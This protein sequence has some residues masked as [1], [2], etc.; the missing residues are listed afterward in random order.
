MAC[1]PQS[2]LYPSI[3]L[4]PK[5]HLSRRQPL[6][7]GCSRAKAQL[8]VLV[9]GKKG[10]ADGGAEALDREEHLLGGEGGS[11]ASWDPA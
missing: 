9:G 5:A 6:H 2:A 7:P 3:L 1:V 4:H 8:I 10:Q 11:M